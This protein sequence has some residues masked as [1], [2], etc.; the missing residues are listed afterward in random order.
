MLKK[1]LPKTK[2]TKDSHLPSTKNLLKPM[3][4]NGKEFDEETVRNQ[5]R[6]MHN[7]ALLLAQQAKVEMSRWHWR[8]ALRLLLK[9]RFVIDS[10]VMITFPEV[11]K[12]VMSTYLAVAK[13]YEILKEYEKSQTWYQ[14]A[15]RFAQLLI[16]EG[17]HEFQNMLCD[18]HEGLGD[19]YF[20]QKRHEE[21]LVEYERTCDLR[22]QLIEAQKTE[23][24]GQDRKNRRIHDNQKLMALASLYQAQIET[25]RSIENQIFAMNLPATAEMWA[26]VEMTT[27]EKFRALISQ[28]EEVSKEYE[29]TMAS[30]AAMFR[31]I[32]REERCQELLERWVAAQKSIFPNETIARRYIN[33]VMTIRLKDLYAMTD[34]HDGAELYHRMTKQIDQEQFQEAFETACVLRS[35]LVHE[36]KQFQDP[37]LIK[38]EFYERIIELCDHGVR[39]IR[40]RCA[41]NVAESVYRN[42]PYDSKKVRAF[43]DQFEEE[44]RAVAE[45]DDESDEDAALYEQDFE[46]AEENHA[47]IFKMLDACAGNNV[48]N[49][50]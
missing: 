12:N 29:Q 6:I 47:M 37:P 11:K 24:E 3:L 39:K 48:V 19:L 21:A 7:E 25:A 17:E 10:P 43:L 9:V 38:R 41:V 40:S 16:D 46:T 28:P 50:L 13:I 35:L 49:E 22:M 33:F 2:S 18:A 5:L 1:A 23:L 31:W 34:F 27:F 36:Q 15:I 45:T 30:C 42:Y 26:T 14:R 4:A 44:K 8:K 20:K 32:G